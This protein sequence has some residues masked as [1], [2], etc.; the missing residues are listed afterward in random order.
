MQLSEKEIEDFIYLDLV[1][2][3]GSSIHERG[4]ILPSHE[5]M[6]Q[7][8]ISKVRWRRQ[9]NIDPYGIIDIVGFYRYCGVIHVDLIE[10]KA[11]PIRSDDFDQVFRYKRGLITYLKNTFK[12]PNIR[13]NCFLIGNGFE[14]GHYIQN[15]ASCVVAEYSYDLNGIQF[16]SHGP[17]ATWYKTSENSNCSFRIKNDSISVVT[18]PKQKF[19]W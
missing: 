5:F 15:N 16:D 12:A 2:N 10:L 6:M 14:S 4:L 3:R 7:P 9:L 19:S 17:N 1:C 11:I 18:R 8:E 13:V